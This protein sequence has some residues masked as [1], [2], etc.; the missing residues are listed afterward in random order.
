MCVNKP[1]L[2]I[3]LCY[4]FDIVFSDQSVVYFVSLP[5]FVLALMNPADHFPQIIVTDFF[6]SLRLLQPFKQKASLRFSP[7]QNTLFYFFPLW[8]FC[9]YDVYRR[10]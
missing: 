1:E 7:A 8:S 4:Q 6:N 9:I 5:L 3:S 10:C 2:F